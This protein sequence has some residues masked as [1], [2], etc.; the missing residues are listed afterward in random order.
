MLAAVLVAYN[1]GEELIQCCEAL[2]DSSDVGI[3]IV[4]DNSDDD[5]RQDLGGRA[6]KKLVEKL[7]TIVPGRNLGY[8]GGNNRGMAVAL[9]AGATHILVCNPDIWI[10]AETVQGL[11]RE[12]ID[13]GLDLISP[14]LKERDHRGEETTLTRPGWDCLVGRG[15]YERGSSV[16]SRVVRPTFFG[17]CVLL[18]G[19]LLK[20]LGGFSEDMFLYGEE[21]DFCRRMAKSPYCW[22]ISAE[23]VAFHERGRSISPSGMSSADRSLASFHHSARSAMIVGRKYWPWMVPL[24]MSLR[25][26][27]A[28]RNLALGRPSVAGTIVRGV[29]SGLTVRLGSNVDLDLRET[30]E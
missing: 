29:Y 5:N 19:S 24:W 28:L 6:S 12:L 16:L 27:L 9:E 3:I 20:A 10:G 14:R 30:E 11:L 1:S 18:K 2:A 4:V 22:A 23:H 25:V 7:R 26:V 13:N 8:S 21:I 17:A 15:V